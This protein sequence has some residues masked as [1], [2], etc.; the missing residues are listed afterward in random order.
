MTIEEINEQVR[1]EPLSKEESKKQFVEQTEKL[2]LKH[3][4]TFEE[5]WE[6]CLEMRKK[7]EYRS[8]ITQ[9]EQEL[10]ELGGLTGD[11][12]DELNPLKHTFAGG[13][14]IREIFNPAGALLVTKIHKKEHPFFLMKGRMSILTENG[15]KTIEAPYNG[16]TKPGTKRVIYTHEECVFITVH[17]TEC[18]TVEEVEDEVIA[19]DFNDPEV[20][21]SDIER[22]NK[23][24]GFDIKKIKKD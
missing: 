11:E 15:I 8:K 18:K 14:Y 6:T 13:C 17:A 3:S 19:K 12:C 20:K 7:I 4:F 9:L 16:I 23:L 5:A 21:L 22:F 2:G 10:V 1:D 24:L